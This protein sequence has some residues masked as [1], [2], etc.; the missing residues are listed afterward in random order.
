MKRRHVILFGSR[1][2]IGRAV[3]TALTG[4]GCQV[5]GM[6]W[7]DSQRKTGREPE[8]ILTQLAVVEGDAD[9]VFASGLTDPNASEAELTLANVE[10]PIA[11]IKATIDRKQF[12]YLTIGS[13]LE[14]FS[15]LAARNRY[16]ASKAALWARIEDLAADPRLHGRVM[17][18]RG[19]TFYGGSPASHL[20]LGQM[21]ESLRT[22]QP[23]RMSEG[24]QLREYAHVED[25]ASSIV[26]LLARAWSVP[27]DVNLST[28]EPIRLSDL[29]RAV[30]RAFDREELLQLGALPTPGGEN[31]DVRFP[32]SPAWLLGHPRPAIEGIVAWF[33]ELLDQPASR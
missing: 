5:Q 22:N 20:F 14:T 18:L 12:R 3:A 27:A 16:L 4:V 6:S 23:L 8:A 17:H 21:Y 13:V 10:R 32:R 29:A 31:L 15:S 19:H 30:Y 11:V 24:R 7:L 1:G 33:S 2:R 25:V 9:I 26:A 28:G